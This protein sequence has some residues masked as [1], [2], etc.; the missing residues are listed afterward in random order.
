MVKWER[1]GFAT[2]RLEIVL[3]RE[4][5]TTQRHNSTHLTHPRVCKEH[6]NER[7]RRGAAKGGTHSAP[8]FRR[9]RTRIEASC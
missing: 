8:A 3:K 5:A 1:E 6:T 4:P 2:R 7:R 9:A